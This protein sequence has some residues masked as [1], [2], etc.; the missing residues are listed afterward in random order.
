MTEWE[1]SLYKKGRELRRGFM[2]GKDRVGLLGG[3]SLG[4]RGA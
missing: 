4:K 2:P 3:G 1:W